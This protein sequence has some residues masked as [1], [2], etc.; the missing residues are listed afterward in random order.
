MR[1]KFDYYDWLIFGTPLPKVSYPK[2]NKP[3]GVK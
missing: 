1:T 2:V 3:K